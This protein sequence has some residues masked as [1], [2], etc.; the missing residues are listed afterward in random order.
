MS[1]ACELTESVLT[2]VAR[3]YDSRNWLIAT[4]SIRPMPYVETYSAL[5]ARM[6]PKENVQSND[7][8]S[9]GTAQLMINAREI[10]RINF[11]IGCIPP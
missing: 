11:F 4:K 6:P 7:E 2:F 10:M 8:A 5:A 9:A 1:A 3:K